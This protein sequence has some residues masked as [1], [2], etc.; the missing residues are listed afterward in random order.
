MFK[1][2]SGTI[3]LDKN[4]DREGP[5]SLVKSRRNNRWIPYYIDVHDKFT[6]PYY[7]YLKNE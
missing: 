6:G 1:G 2:N 4:G 5:I 3:S 7:S